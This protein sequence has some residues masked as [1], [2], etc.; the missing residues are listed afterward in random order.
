MFICDCGAQ[1]VRSTYSHNITNRHRLY[2]LIKKLLGTNLTQEQKELIKDIM[3]LF[4]FK[5]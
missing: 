3:N 5:E 1:L 4:N 2:I